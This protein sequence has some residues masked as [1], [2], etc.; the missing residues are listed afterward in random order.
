MLYESG[1]VQRLRLGTQ[2]RY[3]FQSSPP[4]CPH[5][6]T[7]AVMVHATNFESALTMTGSL[8]AVLTPAAQNRGWTRRWQ[9]AQRDLQYLVAGEDGPLSSETIHAAAQRLQA[10]Y[11]QTYHLKDALRNE[12][13]A[14]GV[15]PAAVEKAI[16]TEPALALLADLANLDKHSTLT[17]AP[18]SGQVPR[19]TSL[20][21]HTASEVPGGWRLRL[22]IDHG[23]KSLDGLQVAQDAV[24]G[25]RRTLSSWGLI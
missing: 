7:T 23:G 2:Y 4:P 6:G 10:F 18:R 22:T 3:S 20:T 9:E 14:T 16:S 19:I 17:K 8:S 5:C 12:A 25:W 21:G 15:S 1:H 13:A 11:V 24:D